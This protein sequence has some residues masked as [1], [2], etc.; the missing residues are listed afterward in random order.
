ML[1][2]PVPT[3]KSVEALQVNLGTSFL[4]SYLLFITVKQHGPPSTLV[5]ENLQSLMDVLLIEILALS[6]LQERSILQQPLLLK[7]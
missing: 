1:E 2:F 6:S 4:N 3:R 7:G 5:S